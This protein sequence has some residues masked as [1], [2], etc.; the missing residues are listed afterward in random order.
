MQRAFRAAV[1]TAAIAAACIPARGQQ[2]ESRMD[3][4]LSQR[5]SH[6]VPG[7]NKRFDAD[8]T[9]R[10]PNRS[11]TRTYSTTEY[12]GKKSFASKGY[13]ATPYWGGDTKFQGTS[14]NPI[15]AKRYAAD[16]RYR[17]K[18]FASAEA[19]GSR[20]KYPTET[21]ETREFRARGKSQ[22]KFDADAKAKPLSIDQVREV[23]NKNE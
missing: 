7:A 10:S 21:V 23:L 11:L 16:E 6:S 20:K 17:T 4:I 12:L 5:P 1:A 15:P 22:D 9:F 14:G 3:Q 8:R 13:R 2:Q 18:E 19:R